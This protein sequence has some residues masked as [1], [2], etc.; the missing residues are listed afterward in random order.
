MTH[1]GCIGTHPAV[2][3]RSHFLRQSGEYGLCIVG[4]HIIRLN[5]FPLGHRI[6]YGIA[7]CGAFVD[8]GFQ[9]FLSVFKRLNSFVERTT[10][11]ILFNE[12]GKERF[13]IE[14]R[15][16]LPDT[17]AVGREESGSGFAT[18]GN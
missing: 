2:G 16:R 3:L 7:Q 15:A 4:R 18:L 12:T 1:N 8:D 11:S 17:D 9:S 5:V 6:V 14:R 13:G 10:L